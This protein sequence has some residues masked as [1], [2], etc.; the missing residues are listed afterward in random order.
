[1]VT[2]VNTIHRVVPLLVGE[3][4]QKAIV[5][6]GSARKRYLQRLRMRTPDLQEKRTAAYQAA[7]ERNKKHGI[8]PVASRARAEALADLHQELNRSKISRRKVKV[9][10]PK[11]RFMDEEIS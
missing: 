10:L 4:T 11:L 2:I 5:T 1:M 9:T 6:R 8:D 3:A 7:V